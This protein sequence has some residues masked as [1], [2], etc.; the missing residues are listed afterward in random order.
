M[1]ACSA[2]NE[3]RGNKGCE[4]IAAFIKM[5]S[6]GR[7][8]QEVGRCGDKREWQRQDGR[9]IKVAVEESALGTP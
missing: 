1:E 3:I 6:E 5:I 7:Q 2:A 9:P 4:V 8:G